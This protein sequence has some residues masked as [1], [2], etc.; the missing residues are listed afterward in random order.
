MCE[1]R[2]FPACINK[3]KGGVADSFDI[4]VLYP[5]CL[6]QYDLTQQREKTQR[7]TQSPLEKGE[8]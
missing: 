4:D 6:V 3:H 7:D 5:I 2:T 8:H 1:G